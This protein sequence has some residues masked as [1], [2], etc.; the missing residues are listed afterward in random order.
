MITERLMCSCCTRTLSKTFP[1]STKMDVR[2]LEMAR[3]LERASWHTLGEIPGRRNVSFVH[4]CDDCWCEIRDGESPKGSRAGS[5][6]RSGTDDGSDHCN[7]CHAMLEPTGEHGDGYDYG[8]THQQCFEEGLSLGGL[9]SD[10]KCSQEL[11][12]HIG[13]G[14]SYFHDVLERVPRGCALPDPNHDAAEAT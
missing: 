7:V 9:N 4:V 13:C 2:R 10:L 8:H 1:E 5:Y 6:Y 12:E 11:A 3:A 14:M